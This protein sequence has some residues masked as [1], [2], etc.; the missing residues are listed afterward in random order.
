MMRANPY[1][2]HL[3]TSSDLVTSREATRAGFVSMALEK[4]R[5]SDPFVAEART[6]RIKA[7]TAKSPHDLLDMEDIRSGLLTAS[8]ISDKALKYLGAEDRDYLLS[9]FIKNFLVPVGKE[10]AEELAYR[11]LMIRGETLGG[12]MKNLVGWWAERRVSRF[13]DSDFKI[14]GRQYQWLNS[15][16]SKWVEKA[17]ENVFEFVRG[18]AW[19]RD[20]KNR[21]LLFNV[22]IPLVKNEGEKDKDNRS[23]GVDIC[24][25]DATPLDLTTREATKRIIENPK[26]YIAL[27]ELKGGIDPAGADEH[28]KTASSALRRIRESYNA[29]GYKPHT[30]LIAAAIEK[31]MADEIWSQLQKRDLANAANLNDETQMVS[32]VDWLCGL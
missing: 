30:F 27:G 11:F 12:K 17:E 4:N 26:R 29:L 13:I 22:K 14:A 16:T 8:G 2:K 24:L 7:A 21:V 6:L 19:T 25:F 1:L 20:R 15:E 23:K 18:F 10:F 31:S 5:V 28:W 3:K 9:E 32:I